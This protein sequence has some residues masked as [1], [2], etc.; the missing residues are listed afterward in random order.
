M[1]SDAAIDF[2]ALLFQAGA[3]VPLNDHPVPFAGIS[4]RHF[5]QQPGG[6]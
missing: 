3:H 2:A 4:A 5:E 6:A 1:Q